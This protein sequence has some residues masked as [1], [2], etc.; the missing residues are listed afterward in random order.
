M[1]VLSILN[2]YIKYYEQTIPTITH[3]V[4]NKSLISR[5]AKQPWLRTQPTKATLTEFTVIEQTYLETTK[6]TKSTFKHVKGHQTGKNFS[7]QAELNNRCD[8][9]AGFARSQNNAQPI[10]TNNSGAIFSINDMEISG[11]TQSTI[12]TA[13][14]SIYL[15][16]YLNQKYQWT[17]EADDIDW[18]LHGRALKLFSFSQK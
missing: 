17:E 13:S 10:N 12:R 3:Y 11:S 7:R 2:L 9:L 8:E 5:L 6:L 18:V 14:T 1:I 15:R 4:D 16:E